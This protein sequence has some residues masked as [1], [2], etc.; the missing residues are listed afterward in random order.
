MEAGLPRTEAVRQVAA[1]SGRDRREVYR[2]T[3]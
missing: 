2:I 3:R 1:R